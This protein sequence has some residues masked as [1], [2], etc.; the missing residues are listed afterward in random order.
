MKEFLKKL[1]RA[2]STAE[3]GELAAARIIS[4]Q[5]GL[6]G[7]RAAI[8]DWGPNRA[9]TKATI[10]AA[11]AYLEQA[12]EVEAVVVASISGQT[13]LRVSKELQ[14]IS[15]PVVCVTGSPSWQNYPEYELPLIPLATQKE[16]DKAGV[17]IVDRVPSS[18]SDTIEFSY[19]RYGFRSP[20]WMF[21]SSDAGKNKPKQTKSHP[22]KP[23][24]KL[25]AGDHLWS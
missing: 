15:I 9:N 23:N 13:A 7:I 2:E 1:V 4:E 24:F 25:F 19:A 17:T 5:L 22:I 21:I 20:T 16:L 12:N 11:R 3:K 8:S 18:L 14:G 10:K 6:S